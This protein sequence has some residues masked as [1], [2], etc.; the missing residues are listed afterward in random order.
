MLKSRITVRQIEAFV[1]VAECNSFTAAAARLKLTTSAVSSLI[2]ELES[3]VAVRL[4]ERSTRKVVLNDAGRMFLP[5]AIAFYR[6][7]RT[8][9]RVAEGLVQHSYGIIRI[10]APMVIASAILPRLIAEFYESF[11]RAEIEIVETGVEWLGERVALGETDFAIGPDRATD[12]VV[13]AEELMPSKWV[14][15]LS[16]DHPLAS[17][18]VLK[19]RDLRGTQFH[20]GG[21]DHERI[22]EQAMSGLAEEDQLVPGR[23]FDNI[24]TALGLAAA[25]LGVT[26]CP[27]YV[28]PMAH[29]FN[30]EMRRLI[31]PEFTRFVV[32]YSSAIRPRNEIANAFARHLTDRFE[33]VAEASQ[34]LREQRSVQ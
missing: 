16:P 25:N 18:P 22:I 24:S 4:F 3:I 30:L 28:A 20:T 32:L 12:D 27:A 8:L 11:P 2:A 29:A 1:S 19:W 5:S 17:K 6:N 34:S 31:D 23:V 9:E 10:A 7:Q 15:W 14:V 26:L 33:A 21:H 13:I